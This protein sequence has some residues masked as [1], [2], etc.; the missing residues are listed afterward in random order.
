MKKLQRISTVIIVDNRTQGEKLKDEITNFINNSY[1]KGINE[2]KCLIKKDKSFTR[3]SILILVDSNVLN[4]RQIQNS[5]EAYTKMNFNI[6]EEHIEA[7][8]RTVYNRT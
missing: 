5:V 2:I 1:K 7:H 8:F 3:L 4:A 6:S